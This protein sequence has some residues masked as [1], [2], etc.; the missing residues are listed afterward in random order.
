MVKGVIFD[1]DGVLVNNMGVHFQAFAAMA[2]RYNLSPESGNNIDLTHLNGRGNDDI[3][4]ALFPAELVAEKGVQALADEKEALY[5][6]IYEPTIKPTEGLVRLLESLHGAGIRCA[7]GSS[8]PRENV[9]FVLR[10]CL[11]EP[12]FSARISGDMVTLCKPD[13]EIFLTA[14]Q[15]LGL[16]PNECLV[17]EDALSGV[18]AAKAAGMKVIALTTTHTAEQLREEGAQIIAKD[19]TT[20]DLETIRSLYKE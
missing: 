11:I 15:K 9:D 13:P 4:T 1:M 8:G 2:M 12:F 19:F 7:V 18:R 10:K 5:R 16:E 14:A 6:E 3:I 20:I 17:F